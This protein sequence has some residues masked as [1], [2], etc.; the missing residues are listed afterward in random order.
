M[1]CDSNQIMKSTVALNDISLIFQGKADPNIQ[2]A[3][4]GF[5][6]LHLIAGDRWKIMHR[7]SESLPI[8]VEEIKGLSWSLYKNHIEENKLQILPMLLAAGADLNA[9]TIEGETPLMTAVL[10]KYP[11]MFH[12]LL[13]EGASLEG[14]LKSEGVL[15]SCSDILSL[16]LA[17]NNTMAAR[18]LFNAGAE[19]GILG[20]AEENWCIMNALEKDDRSGKLR[21]LIEDLRAQRPRTLMIL[22]RKVI[23]TILGSNIQRDACKLGLPQRMCSYVLMVGEVK[24]GKD[25]LTVNSDYY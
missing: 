25:F 17:V 4:I 15:P 19:D 20:N 22:S 1:S 21:E 23:R 13:R 6:P 2:T 24:E 3:N 9:K 7:A 18:I 16:A 11:M 8:Y 10:Y 12:L 14:Q 5:T